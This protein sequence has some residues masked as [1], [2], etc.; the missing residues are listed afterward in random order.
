MQIHTTH[1]MIGARCSY[2]DVHSSNAAIVRECTMQPPR[3]ITLPSSNH[4]AVA[5][6]AY[7]EA[8]KRAGIEHDFSQPTTVEPQLLNA[9][10][11]LG[12]MIEQH[13]KPP[14]DPIVLR[15]RELLVKHN[16]PQ[17]YGVK[18][19]DG[20]LDESASMRAV[21]EALGTALKRKGELT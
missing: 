1:N 16:S 17:P 20:T 10:L 14:V 18:Y 15:A 5:E 12:V 6:W 9:I 11:A 8:W 21:I 3:P 7:K 19:A 4:P 2:C 13:E